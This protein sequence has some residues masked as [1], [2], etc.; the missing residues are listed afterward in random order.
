M[1]KLM[2]NSECLNPVQ[3]AVIRNRLVVAI[4]SPHG[5]DRA[6]WTAIELLQSRNLDNVELRQ[7]KVPHDLVNWI[8]ACNYLVK[9]IS[10]ALLLE[11]IQYALRSSVSIVIKLPEFNGVDI[12]RARIRVQVRERDRMKHSCANPP[13]RATAT[14]SRQ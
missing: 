12:A 1:G 3:S 2:A 11:S 6:G 4:G 9:P 10:L 5:D 7:A 14:H 13:T 8:D